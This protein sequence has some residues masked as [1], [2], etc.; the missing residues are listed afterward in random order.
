MTM[1]TAIARS[2]NTYFYAMGRRVG[3]DRIAPMARDLGLG[4]HFDLPVVSQS[5]GTMPD[6]AMEETAA[7]AESRAV[8]APR[9]DRIGHAQRVDRPGLCHRQSAPARHHGRLRRLGPQDPAAADRRRRP[10]A[11]ASALRS[12]PFRDGA[13]GHVGGGQRPRH[14][15]AQ[16]PALPRYR[17]GRQDRHRPGAPHRRRPAR[18]ERRLEISR[19]RPVRLLRAR[20]SGRAT[21]ARW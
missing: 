1:H 18:P 19:P 3:I 4:Q 2:C 13:G 6:S 8:P 15:R 5:Y 16:P 17:D 9:L 12:G 20:S 11:A 10:G 21:P 14:G 7:R